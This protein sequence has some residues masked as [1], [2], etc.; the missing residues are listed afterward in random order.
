[1][2]LG[3]SEAIINMAKR[4][5]LIIAG[6]DSSGGAGLEA[7]QKVIVAHGCYAMTATTALTAQN[8]LGVVDIHYTPPGFVRKL[9]DTCIS[10]IGV[11]VVKT[12]M[13]A[14]AE[15]IQVVAEAL[16]AHHVPA[17]VIDPV[18][19]STSG[20]Q[21][22]PAHAVRDLREKLLPIAT[23]ITPNVPEAMLLLSDSGKPAAVAKNVEGLIEIAKAVQSLGPKYV[24]VKGG[25]LPFRMDGNVAETVKE[26]EL[27]VDILYGD[28]TVT[29]IHTLYQPS[30]NTHGTGCSL[31]SAIASNLAN[32]LPMVQAVERACRYV[33]AGIKTATDLGRGNGPINHF[34]STYTLPFPP[35]RFLE[36]V[37][38]RRDVQTP[39]KEHTEHAFVAG[40][41]DGTLPV[42]SFKYYLIQDYL[43]LVQ[44]A[45]ANSL[46]AYKA[47]T[48]T[49]IAAAAKI[50]GHI[51]HEMEL[52]IS[53]CQEFGVSKEE[54]EAS[55][56]SHACTAYT[57]YVLDIGQS[58]DWF[59]LQVA[60]APCLIGYGEIAKR[61]H[62]DPGTKRDGNIYGKWIENY[63]ADDYVEAVK[64]GSALLERNAVLQSPHRIEELVKIFIHATKMETGF[65][66]MGAGKKKV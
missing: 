13:L 29:K 30:K 6:S 37:L 39:W 15:T 33:E 41:A 48:I 64:V 58:Q 26:K 12:G 55:E 40:L 3:I 32:G 43:F 7:D 1:M 62:A 23:I 59:A 24:L 35:G 50:V 18:M 8:T 10:D 20:H 66:D 4:R 17:T 61:L 31:A 47:K 11:D 28:G 22:L 49:D 53:Y 52:H 5:V 54:I 42:E 63:V 34:H 21:L 27:M 16:R 51:H 57:R 46:A 65:W 9:I 19:V 45:R 25:H 44:F 38:E 14:S 36:Y 56:E 60:L 2:P